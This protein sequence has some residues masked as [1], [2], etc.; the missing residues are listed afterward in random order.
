MQ[1]PEIKN[2]AQKNE[3]KEDAFNTIAHSH[4]IFFGHRSKQHQLS[5]QPLLFFCMPCTS[6]RCQVCPYNAK[7]LNL[8]VPNIGRLR[9]PRRP[10]LYLVNAYI[11]FSL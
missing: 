10:L 1:Q 9:L 3:E 7:I 8:L 6:N 2:E 4:S 5:Y 11:A